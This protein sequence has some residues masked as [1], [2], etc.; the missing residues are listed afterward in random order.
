MSKHST[1]QV[2]DVLQMCN[3]RNRIESFQ[4]EAKR[5]LC[6]D[7]ADRDVKRIEELLDFGGAQDIALPEV[8]DLKKV[9]F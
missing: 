7:R 1:L 5:Q 4:T 9:S 2:P 3:L 8:F 6:S